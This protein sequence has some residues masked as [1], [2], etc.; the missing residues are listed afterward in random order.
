[1]LKDKNFLCC[2]L[3]SALGI[4]FSIFFFNHPVHDYGNYYFGSTFALQGVNI[5]DI[6]EPY[7]FNLLIRDQPGML[8]QEFFDNYAVVP[9]FTLL[10]YIPFTLADVYTSKFAFNIFSV[11]VFCFFLLR[12]LRHQDIQSPFVFLLLLIFIVPFRNNILFGQ[13][14][15]LVTGF[16][17]A[18]FVAEEKKKNLA[19]AIFYSLAIAHKIS[20]AI[21]LLYLIARKNFRSVF[22]TTLFTAAL[23]LASVYITGW[24]F[25]KEYFLDYIPRM[26]VNE[27]NNPY[28]TTYQSITILLRNLFIPDQLLNPSAIFNSPV[29]FFI[30]S[31]LCTGTLFFFF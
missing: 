31:G 30:L 27:I 16:L 2:I 12:L 11:F 18:G 6:Y 26:S 10:F 15:L 25:M 23:F 29:T 5:R 24:N 8:H 28:A 1:M 14:Y 9:P 21:L 20:P 19:A 22:L 17:L 7:K 4:F 13:T 3:L